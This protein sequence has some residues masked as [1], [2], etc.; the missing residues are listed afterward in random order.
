M[1]LQAGR[2]ASLRAPPEEQSK[3]GCRAL[4]VVPPQLAT[5]LHPNPTKN[6][7]PM[8]DVPINSFYVAVGQRIY[9]L[10]VRTGLSQ[11]RF[12]KLVGYSGPMLSLIERGMRDANLEKLVRI[13]KVLGVSTDYLLTGESK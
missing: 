9:H 4:G 13:A 2:T 5:L 8:A 1:A 7:M 3:R 10:R 11:A 6:G 12:G